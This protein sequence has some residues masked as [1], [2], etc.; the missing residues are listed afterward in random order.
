[1]PNGKM[2][3]KNYLIQLDERV[4]FLTE[5]I[6]KIENTNAKLMDEVVN[7]KVKIYV[8]AGSVSLI[9]SIVMMILS[10]FL[11]F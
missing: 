10:K 2:T 5:S 8:I 6:K 4:K 1:M 9:T 3:I 11:K 7:L